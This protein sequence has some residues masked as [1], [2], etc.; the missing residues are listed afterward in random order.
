MPGNSSWPDRALTFGYARDEAL[1]WF[2][3][4]PAAWDRFGQ[5]IREGGT[6]ISESAPPAPTTT[7]LIFLTAAGIG[8]V[9]LLVDTCAVTLRSAAVAGLPLFALYAVPSAVVAGGAPL[10]Y[11]LLGAIGYLG[12]LMADGRARLGGWG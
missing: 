7:G 8:F 4:G 3:P 11:F 12:L 9:A 5:L 1:F 6:T 2:I 10:L